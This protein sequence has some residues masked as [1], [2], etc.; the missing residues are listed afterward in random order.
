MIIMESRR[1]IRVLYRKC[2]SI[3]E[4][5]RITRISLPTVRK[6]IRSDEAQSAS[7]KRAHQP[8]PKLGGYKEML[9]K[10]LRDNK[11]AKPKRNGMMLFE[12]LRGHGYSGSYSAVGR[13]VAAW[14]LRD[15]GISLDA[16]VPLYFAPGEAFHFLIAPA[17]AMGLTC[18]A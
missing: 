8:F 18:S 12:E 13:Y 3:R 14:K 11:F 17:I 6:I 2:G 15:T 10:L 5:S 9:E 4:V 7:Y 16:C 1:K